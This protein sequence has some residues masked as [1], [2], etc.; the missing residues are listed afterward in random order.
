ML[1][2]DDEPV[3]EVVRKAYE[4]ENYKFMTLPVVPNSITCIFPYSTMISI[5]IAVKRVYP[6]MR[7]YVEVS[8]LSIC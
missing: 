2:E 7:Q 6:R 3:D 4:K 5:L 8:L 1:A